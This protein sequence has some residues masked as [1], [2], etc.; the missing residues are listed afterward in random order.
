MAG[1]LGLLERIRASL[2]GGSAS[3]TI[4]DVKI[5]C[6]VVNGDIVIGRDR[7]TINGRDVHD[8]TGLRVPINVQVEGSLNSLTVHAGDVTVNGDVGR[9][10]TE[11]GDVA[12]QGSVEGDVESEAGDV[13]IGGSVA[14][15]VASSCGDV[16]IGKR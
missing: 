7:V 5:A 8:L 13:R 3:V 11:A 10:S 16:T 15:S 14:G 12:I 4:N 6:N 1:L 9:L 2:F